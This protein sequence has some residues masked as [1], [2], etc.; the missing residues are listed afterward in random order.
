MAAPGSQPRTG[1]AGNKTAQNF[2]AKLWEKGKTEQEIRQTLKDY[3]YK[4]GRISQLI[5]ATRPTEGQAGAMAATVA[6]GEARALRRPAA[7]SGVLRRP[8]AASGS[9]ELP[10]ESEVG[11]E[12][13]AGIET[14]FGS[15]SQQKNLLARGSLVV[16][17]R[18]MRRRLFCG[19]IGDGGRLGP[20]C[21]G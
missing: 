18:S 9:H 7:A 6:P 12:N 5:K 2:V 10:A 20:H 14:V 21:T 16:A 13:E 17:F 1:G 15:K 8:P 3:S 19:S 4:A 11:T